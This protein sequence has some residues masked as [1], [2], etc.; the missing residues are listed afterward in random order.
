MATI[1]EQSDTR[2]FSAQTGKITASRTFVIFDDAAPLTTPAAVRAFFNSTDLPQIGDA[3]PGESD[4]FATNYEIALIPDS[5]N[6][7]NVK[8][9]YENTEPGD[10]QPIEEGY[11]EISIDYR[12]EFRDIYRTGPNVPANG[13][14]NDQDIGGTPIDAGGSPISKIQRQSELMITE[15][16][17]FSSFPARSLLIRA[18]RGCR[19]STV[20]QGAPL[21]QVLYQGASASRIAINKMQIVHRFAQDEFFHLIQSPEKNQEGE[22]KKVLINSVWRAEKVRFVQPFPNGYDFNTLSENF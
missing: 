16:V 6:A 5:S 12:A 20:F 2:S 14:P 10:L 3:F 1:V 9:S 21:G 15:V 11:T 18:A 17:S 7:W 4:I 22:P 19:N 13:N 8:F